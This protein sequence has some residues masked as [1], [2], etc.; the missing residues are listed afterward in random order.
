VPDE[1]IAGSAASFTGLDQWLG[2]LSDRAIG[3]NAPY[4]DNTSAAAARM[5]DG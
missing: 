2:Q 4:S 3:V 5:I 1:E